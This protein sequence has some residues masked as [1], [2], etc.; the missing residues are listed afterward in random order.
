M[1]EKSNLIEE[2]QEASEGNQNAGFDASAFMGEAVSQS[3][4]ESQEATE[5]SEAVEEE[6]SNTSEST[7]DGFS[8]DSVEVEASQEEVV[9]EETQETQEE[10]TEEDD[11]WD[12]V[13]ETE[14]SSD[15]SWEAVGQEMGIEASTKEELVQKVKEALNP[16]ADNDAIGNL[17]GYLELTDKD[18]VI[19]DM[20]ASKYEDADI[21]DTVSRLE[22]SGL[23]KREATLIRNQLNKHISSEQDKIRKEKANA[24]KQ[25]TENANKSRKELQSYIKGK[26][27]FFGG[28]VSQ[29]DKKQ[30]YSYI[31]KGGFAQ[32]IFESHANVA[33]AAFLWQNKEKI[34]K[35]I[36]TQGVEQG[37]SKILDDITSPNRGGRSIKNFD[38]GD[39]NFNPNKFMAD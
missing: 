34:F 4:E 7:D 2:A 9:T 20:K 32:D 35:M 19:A 17:K 14:I 5:T 37:K 23:L 6:E 33:E 27:D 16:V 36:K 28:K 13:T 21:E 26:E 10:A 11:D 15:D 12:S 24:E 29:K 38:K 31:T 1:V 8:W 3:T 22:S 39:G 18:L 30:L 25:K